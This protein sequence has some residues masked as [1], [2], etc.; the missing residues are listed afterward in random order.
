MSEYTLHKHLEYVKLYAAG[1]GMSSPYHAIDYAK[2][3]D[4]P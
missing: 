4:L 2:I 1:T 3:I